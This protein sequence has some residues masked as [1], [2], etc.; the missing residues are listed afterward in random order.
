[1]VSAPPPVRGEVFLV[2]LDPTLGRE[3]RKTRPCVIVSPDELNGAL[4]TFIVAPLT[5][6]SHPYPFRI[7]CRL[8]GKSGHV[9]LDQIRTV[10][11]ARLVKKV[12]RLSPGTLESVLG[13]L[14]E[15]FAA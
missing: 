5:T 10:D 9:V 14:Q 15:M 11:R 13:V 12:G 2:A 6:G 1:M 7:P 4:S 8:A 3:I